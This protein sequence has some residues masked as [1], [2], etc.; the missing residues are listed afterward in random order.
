MISFEALV[1]DGVISAED[2]SLF[3]YVETAEEAWEAI[4]LAYQND[5]PAAIARQVATS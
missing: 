1:E 3:H 5:D 4:K 2:L